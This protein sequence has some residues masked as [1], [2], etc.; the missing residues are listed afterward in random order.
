MLI[1]LFK[2]LF[3]KSLNILKLLLFTNLVMVSSLSYV[4]G[5]RQTT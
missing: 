4:R 3:E 2:A 5:K 1:L